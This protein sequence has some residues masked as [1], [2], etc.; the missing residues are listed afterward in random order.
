MYIRKIK[1]KNRKSGKVYFTYRLVEAIR[2]SQ[3][4]KQ[5]IVLNLGRHF[6]VEK[7]D[8]LV[9]AKRIEAIL[10][11][12]CNLSGMDTHL[13]VSAQ[14][15]AAMI[16]QKQDPDV[17]VDKA[18]YHEVDINSLQM[19]RPRS[20]GLEY[21]CLHALRQLKLDVKLLQLGF[22]RHNLNAALATIIGRMSVPGSELATFNWIQ[23]K[24]GL[25]EL[26]G[27]D[28]GQMSLTRI[29]QVSDLLLKHKKQIEDFLYPIECELFEFSDTVT[30]YDLTNT[31]FEGSGKFNDLAARG[32]SKEKRTD[33][34][35]VTLALVLDGSGFPKSSQVYEGNACESKTLQEMLNGLGAGLDKNISTGQE[36]L[37]AKPKPTIIMD[38]G[39]ATEENIEW[40]KK[41][42]Y[43]YL[44]VSRKRHRE[45]DA[46]Q[47]VEV[48]KRRDYTIHV[49]KVVN[50][51]T[52]EVELY[53]K[54]SQKEAKEKAIQDQFFTKFEESME[55]LNLGLSRKGCVKRYEKV[56]ES[57]GRIRQKY[58]KAS[59]HYKI[60][61]EKQKKGN[62]AKAITWKRNVIEDTAD[63]FPG[64]YC[65]RTNLKDWDEST[66]WRTY[67]ML[68][69]LEAVFR[70]LKSE[71]G[72]RPV[73][74][75]K[76]DRVSG[77]LFITLLAYHAVHTIRYQLK[78]KEIDSS[79]S[80]LRKQL[81]GQVRMT[82]TMKTK[83]NE[84]I[85]IRKSNQP[86]S[87][88]RKIYEILGLD[89]LP[90]WT[91]KKIV[92]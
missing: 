3:S 21:V 2:T 10:S 83:D 90:G 62:N 75:Q 28:Y 41:E 11:G 52:D 72:L 67:T 85:N 15:Y 64:V 18:Q 1:I 66:L 9:L 37:F 47:A 30:L 46:D 56:L 91:V 77:H 14:R 33:C 50:E 12:Q 86:E 54:S 20:V 44:V 29:Y 42:K 26:L 19:L 60:T 73:F 74:H 84:T 16:L 39:I 70:S 65:L 69:D 82:V 31:Y 32:K 78:K 27:Y 71:L 87:K 5:R 48:R 43:R 57:I 23:Q 24:S 68:T 17:D 53:C 38:A 51:G 63:N 13:E 4:V 88:Q 34:P 40:L 76:T 61:V 59:K 92:K 89:M 8:W 7:K 80:N 6:A 22:S 25:G 79:W 36:S 55:K 49:Q 58:G 35:L 81:C 45:F